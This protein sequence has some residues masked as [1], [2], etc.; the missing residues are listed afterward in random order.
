MREDRDSSLTN[1]E[2]N[3]FVLNRECSSLSQNRLMLPVAWS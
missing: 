3:E 2:T 1:R